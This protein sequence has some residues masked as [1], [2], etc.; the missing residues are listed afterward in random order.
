MGVPVL[1]LFNGSSGRGSLDTRAGGSACSGRS[2]QGLLNEA[3]SP[4]PPGVC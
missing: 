4:K 1:E 2:H 3:A